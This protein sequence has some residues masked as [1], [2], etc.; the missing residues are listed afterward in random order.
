MKLIRI[1]RG[2]ANCNSMRIKDSLIKHIRDQR[3]YKVSIERAENIL[4][5]HANHNVKL[6]VANLVEN[7]EKFQDWD[8]PTYYNIVMLKALE[9]KSP[10]AL[11]AR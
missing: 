5:F 9:A 8:N 4:S 11:Y 1:D 6:I 10:A 2:S 3:N 7:V